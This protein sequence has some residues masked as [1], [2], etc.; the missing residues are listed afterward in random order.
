M[1]KKV[2]YTLLIILIIIL[3]SIMA[4]LLINRERPNTTLEPNDL[5][6]ETTFQANATREETR[7][8]MLEGKLYYDTGSDSDITA[9]CG[10]MDGQ[11]TSTVQSDETPSENNQSNFGTDYGYQFVDDNNVDVVIGEHWVRFK[12]VE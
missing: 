9:R 5:A 10:V 11:I 7:M 2:Y 1:N 6:K 8:V 3:V 4:F 12:A